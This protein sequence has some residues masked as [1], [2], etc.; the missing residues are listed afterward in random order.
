VMGLKVMRLRFLW[1]WGIIPLLN[2]PAVAQSS[3]IGPVEGFVFD[4]PSR[5]VRPVVGLV[6]ASSFGPILVRGVDY[7]SVAPRKDYALTVRGDRAMLVSGLGS[8]IPAASA[9]PFT[10]RSPEGAAWSDDGSVA[11]LYSRSGNWIQTVA[12]FPTEVTAASSIDLTPLGGSLAVVAAD[13]TGQ[14]IAIGMGGD[15][16]GVYVMDSGHGFA[17][18]LPMAQ[19]IGLAFSSD[20]R[21][22]YTLDGAAAQIV[23]V[24]LGSF[25]SRSFPLNGLTDPV[26]L[27]V[28]PDSVGR[29]TIYV[30]GRS[31][32][33]LQSYD[34]SSNALLASVPLGFAPNSI[35][36]FGNNTYVLGPRASAIEPLWSFRAGPMPAVYFI[37]AAPLALPE[38]RRK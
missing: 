11:V 32:R 5:G 17:E 27:A 38:G 34:A 18:I 1:C 31:D 2:L 16:G 35:A 3:L 12:G 37:P 22:L 7:A 13:L 29:Q 28:A 10:I 8:G 26:A 24:D 33:M 30:A 14:H 20:G 25:V 6:G 9:L 15:S 36:A 19:P 4:A 23:A 21:T